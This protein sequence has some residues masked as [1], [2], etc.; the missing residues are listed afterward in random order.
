MK[1]TNRRY[2][3]A[4]VSITL[5]LLLAASI[6][7][8][9]ENIRFSHSLHV[10]EAEIGCEVCHPGVRDVD[11]SGQTLLPLR[12][13]CAECHDVLDPSECVL[14][15]A[16]ED[17]HPLCLTTLEC[18]E[19][20]HETH[21]GDQPDCQTCHEGIECTES[22]QET[23]RPKVTICADC[24]R[25]DRIRPPS[26]AIG[27]H[28]GH[29]RDAELSQRTCERCHLEGD[30]C[31]ACHHG[32]N[33]TADAPHPLSFLYSHGPDARLAEINCISCH[34]S[35][36]YCQDCHTA[37]GV[38]PLSHDAAGWISVGHG[39]EGRRHLEQC[40]GCHLE[41]NAEELCGSCHQ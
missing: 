9:F 14:C 22:S 3:P 4:V 2:L 6:R 11:D 10:E 5:L 33:L 26:H 41:S 28:N 17:E 32:D 39:L 21:M 36:N 12:G 38:K 34:G 8:G 18:R 15:H 35:E 37:Y 25:R 1:L 16:S 7:A 31:E 29:G 13:N 30:D 24:H 20:S 40:I 23:F 27:W 19:F